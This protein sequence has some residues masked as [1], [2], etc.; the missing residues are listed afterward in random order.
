MNCQKIAKIKVALEMRA[1]LLESCKRDWNER[2]RVFWWTPAGQLCGSYSRA[3][4]RK[5]ARNFREPTVWNVAA[6]L[7]FCSDGTWAHLFSFGSLLREDRPVKI[8]FLRLLFKIEHSNVSD[9]K[10]LRVLRNFWP[11]YQNKNVFEIK[12]R[13]N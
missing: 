1:R 13:K 11:F 10:K 7:K 8:S 9:L 3:K 12:W 4:W 5:P 2:F 6:G